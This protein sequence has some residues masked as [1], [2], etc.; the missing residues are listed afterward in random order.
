MVQQHIQQFTSSLKNLAA[1]Y[2][3]PRI[4]IE[5]MPLLKD[6]PVLTENPE[7]LGYGVAGIIGLFILK[8]M[9]FKRRARRVKSVAMVMPEPYKGPS[10]AEL[11]QSL[12]DTPK[13]TLRRAER[14]APEPVLAPAPA[15]EPEPRGPAQQLEDVTAVTFMARPALTPDEARAR[16]VM[17]SVLNDMRAPYTIMSRT[18]LNALIA[19]DQS[20]M[21][22]TRKHAID[23][24]EGK[25]IDMG[26]FDRA[27]RLVL[28]VQVH[29]GVPAAGIAALNRAVVHQALA[30]AGIPAIEI[31]HTDTPGEMKQKISGYLNVNPSAAAQPRQ[32][33]P[34]PQSARTPQVLQTARPGRP[35]RPG[36][37]ARP[38]GP[39]AIAAE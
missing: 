21:G 7:Y 11:A 6:Y 31:K 10:D 39:S 17:Q 28:A 5:H 37:P 27:G 15:Q 38:A 9:V 2:S 4:I 32:A 30:Q 3:D 25:S 18:A 22:G 14:S 1:D 20:A 29:T 33:A 13:A 36:R 26:L 24:I 23:A 34:A 12:A 8:K 19:P 16:V 35:T